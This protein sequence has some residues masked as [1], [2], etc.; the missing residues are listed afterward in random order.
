M[1]VLQ[2]K[3]LKIISPPHPPHGMERASLLDPS[4]KIGE[5][6]RGEVKK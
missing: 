6:V 5:G 3:S 4:L 1:L 2:E